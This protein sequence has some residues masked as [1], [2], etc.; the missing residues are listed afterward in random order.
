MPRRSRLDEWVA[1]I[2]R[3][4]VADMDATLRESGFVHPPAVYLLTEDLH[5]PLVGSLTCRQFYRGSD[6]EVA[7]AGMGVLP[8]AL[9]AERLV[10]SWEHADLCTA[11]ELSGPAQGF[12]PGVVV[13]DADRDIH[14]V[15]WHPMRIHVGERESAEPPTFIPEWGPATREI[16]GGLPIAVQRLLEV[17]RKPREWSEIEQLRVLTSLE[18]AGYSMRWVQREV[19]ERD[20]NWARL[21]APMMA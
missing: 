15:N 19:S 9:A 8:A 18:Q 6:A 16:G 17:W 11:L 3:A 12:P 20:P 14:V 10:V 5:P 21:L 7:V 4:T 2:E 13:I 1:H